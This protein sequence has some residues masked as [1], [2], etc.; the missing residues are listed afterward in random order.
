MKKI[1]KQILILLPLTALA[2]PNLTFAAYCDSVGIQLPN[3]PK[4][5]Q[6]IDFFTCLL[7]RSV[8]PLLIT[9][10]IVIFIWGVVQFIGN[11]D[12]EEKQQ[13]GRQF[14]MWGILGLFVI[15]SVWGLVR[16]LTNTFNIEFTLPQLPTH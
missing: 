16:I 14:M 10:A 1:K 8:V 3:S 12:N 2:I 13:K 5:A 9:S 4:I 6:L 15:V 7:S 11:A